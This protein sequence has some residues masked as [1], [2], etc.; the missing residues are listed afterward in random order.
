MMVIVALLDE[1]ASW[2]LRKKTERD[3]HGYRK[4]NC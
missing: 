1:S 2:G 4:R 3:I